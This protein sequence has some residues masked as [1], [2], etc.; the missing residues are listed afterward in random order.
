MEGTAIRGTRK[1]CEVTRPSDE[2]VGDKSVDPTCGLEA[3]GCGRDWMFDQAGLGLRM[4]CM[5]SRVY[6]VTYC[7]TM[8]GI[9]WVG[10]QK[11]LAALIRCDRKA[12]CKVIGGMC[13]DGLIDKVEVRGP[14]TTGIKVLRCNVDKAEEAYVRWC[15]ANGLVLCKGHTD[16]RTAG[17]EDTGGDGRWAS[18]IRE[19]SHKA[20][21][22]ATARQ[23]YD[24]VMAS[25]QKRHVSARDAKEGL[26]AYAALRA[27][28]H[29]MEAIAKAI[30]D[31]QH[32]VQRTN[33]GR[34]DG[35]DWQVFLKKPAR[36]FEAIAQDPACAGYAALHGG[37]T[38]DKAGGVRRSVPA[39]KE[40]TLLSAR[41][42]NAYSWAARVGWCIELG[43]S[44]HALDVLDPGACVEALD[45]AF[46]RSA[47]TG[48]RC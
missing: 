3:L 8:R 36:M 19:A 33:Q 48:A 29:S 31:Y 28:G 2:L 4:G 17:N 47:R 34:R 11:E 18:S 32:D 14:E 46:E 40:G 41:T 10:S 24:Q 25:Y 35:K 1:A 23:E 26:E 21:E 7:C 16:V 43:S 27:D 20:M 39:P 42:G 13:R 9:G 45:D 5:A 37:A 30:D 38:K 44:M 6:L 12:L 15:K 22:P